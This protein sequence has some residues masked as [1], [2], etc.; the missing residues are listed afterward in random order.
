MG[1]QGNFQNIFKMFQGNNQQFNFEQFIPMLLNM[2]GGNNSNFQN[3]FQNLIKEGNNDNYQDIFQKIFKECGNNNIN[4]QD[5]FQ[6]IFKDGNNTNN[7]QD[8]FQNIFKGGN[9]NNNFQDIFQNIFKENC[10]SKEEDKKCYKNNV[11]HGVT[12]DGCNISPIVGIRYKCQGCE[13]FDFCEKCH[14]ELKKNHPSEH[15]FIKI[16]KTFLQ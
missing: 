10:Q 2:F 13:N 9:N 7:F 14:I 11:H 4:F 12:C 15:Q 8:I 3:I 1:G 5:I 16:E 6:N